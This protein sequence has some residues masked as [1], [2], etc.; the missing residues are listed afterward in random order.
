MILHILL[1]FLMIPP[2]QPGSFRFR[3]VINLS[4]ALSLSR[5]RPFMVRQAHY[6]RTTLMTLKNEKILSPSGRGLG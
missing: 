6:E 5:G 3:L 1:G 4:F 2:R